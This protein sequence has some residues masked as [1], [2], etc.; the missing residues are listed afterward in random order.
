MWYFLIYFITLPLH[1]ENK[2]ILLKNVKMN[3]K[4]YI[5]N[6]CQTNLKKISADL[7]HISNILLDSTH[8]SGSYAILHTQ[9]TKNFPKNIYNCNMVFTIYGFFIYCFASGYYMVRHYSMYNFFKI[10]II[11]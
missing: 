11:N 7:L 3:R 2:I 6:G 10:K 9:I 5:Y 4:N 8:T 1:P